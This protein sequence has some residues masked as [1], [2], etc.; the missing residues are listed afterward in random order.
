MMI[1]QAHIN[2]LEEAID[3]FEE[4][5]TPDSRDGMIELLK[6]YDL[7]DDQAALTE[8]IRVDIELR[9]KSGFNPQLEDYVGRFKTRLTDPECIALIA[10][11]DFRARNTHGHSLSPA[12]WRNMPGVRDEAWFRQLEDPRASTRVSRT[13][14]RVL[15]T[16]SFL[17]KPDPAFEHEL[18]DA[19]FRL[20]HEI[21]Q[22]AFSRVY[23]AIQ[24]DLADRYVV[25]KVVN[26]ALTEPQS[27]AM[28]QH[29]NI[30]PIYSFHKILS[31]SVMC[32]PY[33]GSV[34]LEQFLRD[35]TTHETRAGESLV[36]TVRSRV[37]ESTVVD[38]ELQPVADAKPVPLM[39]AAHDKAVLKPLEDLQNLDCGELAIW[40]FQRL[41]AALAHS[42]A[43][44]VLHGDLK[45]AN[46]LIR[47]DGEPA[48]LDFNL[49]QKLDR[50]KPKHFGG[51]LPYMPPESFRVLMGQKDIEHDVTSDIY[52]LGMMLFEFVTGRLAYT[53][54]PSMA[55]ADLHP[56]LRAR[57]D[58]PPDWRESDLVSESLKAI[59]NRCLE[60]DPRRRYESAEA[61]QRDLECEQAN[62]PLQHAREPA[63]I[64]F[65][66]WMR[67][68]PRLLSGGTAAVIAAMLLIVLGSFAAAWRNESMS[69][70]SQ[71][72][73]EEFEE[74]S[75]RALT[76]MLGSPIMN[77]DR[78]VDEAM[79][80][81]Q[82]FGIGEGADPIPFG[83]GTGE[84]SR[85]SQRDVVLRHIV[86][87]GFL[88]CQVLKE[89]SETD[90]QRGPALERLAELRS[91]G[92]QVAGGYESRG[93][94]W[95]DSKLA[96]LSGDSAL[97]EQLHQRALAMPQQNLNEKYLEAIRLFY[98]DELDQSQDLLTEL[99]DLNA[100]PPVIRWTALGRT[101][102]RAGQNLQAAL[103]YTQALEHSPDSSR[104][105]LLRCA[106]TEDSSRQQAIED[107]NNSIRIN[108]DEAIAY[109]RRGLLF[110]RDKKAMTANPGR[111]LDDFSRALEFYPH[112]VDILLARAQAY[113]MAGME[114]E[115]EADYQF[116][117]GLDNL[118]YEGLTIRATSRRRLKNDV[119]GAIQ[120]LREAEKLKPDSQTIKLNLSR[121]LNR[122]GQTEAAVAK[123]TELLNLYPDDESA[124]VD[125]AVSYAYLQRFDDAKQDIALVV[126]NPIFP[127]TLYQAAC[128]CALMPDPK[129]HMQGVKYLARA[130]VRG[131]D[132]ENRLETDEDLE[133]LRTLPG[134][135]ALRKVDSLV[136]MTN[137]SDS[138]PTKSGERN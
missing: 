81:L 6:T 15:P 102:Q 128:A 96:D 12:R 134:F 76:E 5:W 90:E 13:V 112:R 124:R 79:Q 120:D 14:G 117:M 26:E 119:T 110:I 85:E 42:H 91:L 66:K 10:F 25:L 35:R 87:T 95:L 28:L 30:V 74:A 86:H 57:V 52:G 54:P 36:M 129:S 73:F 104:L 1:D 121:N 4:G 111:V 70:K 138:K 82:D 88:E 34:T 17:P 133:S 100:V 27:L 29:T 97:A 20:I 55:P 24:H 94:V 58:S 92:G 99:A 32:M 113:R 123:L 19:G 103:S 60:S 63:R 130:R 78:G 45:P 8:L 101:Q 7:E 114:R 108:P 61:L 62:L 21:G 51:T 3:S 67:R 33:A 18:E 72:R 39:P 22:G 68:H 105:Y 31:R 49:S 59:I 41:S 77:A 37:Q 98:D 107:V 116:A 47:N 65:R 46:V 38:A 44:G 136:A 83:Q 23:L 75:N 137:N 125:R 64:R 135:R 71:T 11:E 16:A 122:L 127:R 9:Y 40:V 43:R 2:Q 93:L 106:V 53:P 89:M 48:L 80:T 84:R 118:R 126:R 50:A 132:F 115:A 131:Y 56:A 69:M 109:H